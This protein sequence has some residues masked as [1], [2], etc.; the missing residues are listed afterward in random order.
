MKKSCFACNKIAELL[1][2]EGETSNKRFECD[3][4]GIYEITWKIYRFW[5]YRPFPPGNVKYSKEDKIKIKTWL[6]NQGSNKPGQRF[7]IINLDE[8]KKILKKS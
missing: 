6:L 5:E 4:C 3:D 7:P 8:V 2:T 1:E